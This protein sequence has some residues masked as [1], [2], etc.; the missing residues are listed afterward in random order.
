MK[1]QKPKYVIVD[2][3]RKKGVFK[4]PDG[5]I[6]YDSGMITLMSHVKNIFN[7]SKARVVLNNEK[8]SPIEMFKSIKT[9]VLNEGTSV[10]KTLQYKSVCDK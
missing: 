1:A 6:Q 5:T 7:A 3:A 4:M 8:L 2:S 10:L 9:A